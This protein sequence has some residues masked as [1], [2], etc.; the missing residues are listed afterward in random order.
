MSDYPWNDKE[1]VRQRSEALQ[2]WRNEVKRQEEEFARA[3]AQEEREQQRTADRRARNEAA[4]MRREFEGRLAALEQSHNELSSIV[5]GIARE[6]ADAINSLVDARDE[7][8]RERRD[9]IRE[10]RAAVA[11]MDAAMTKMDEHE[12]KAFRFAREKADEVIDL[13]NPLPPRRDMN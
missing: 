3:R 9:E 10:L 8:T 4:L 5:A 13:P 2:Q 1:A 12:A 7:L 11:K 6:A